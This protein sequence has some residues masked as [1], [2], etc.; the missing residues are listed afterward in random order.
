MTQREEML[1]SA[2][3]DCK[4]EGIVGHG[5][6]QIPRPLWGKVLYALELY[7]GDIN[8]IRDNLTNVTAIGDTTTIENS[9]FP[10]N[11]ARCMIQSPMGSFCS[12]SKNHI[13]KH[14]A[15]Y[16]HDY[17]AARMDEWEDPICGKTTPASI[18]SGVYVCNLLKGHVGSHIAYEF[19]NPIRRILAKWD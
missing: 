13:G 5:Y 11:V 9:I 1:V 4:R 12:L 18:M 6:I 14:I 17:K 2:V 19:S 16:Q 7:W 15:F 10:T 3:I 8:P